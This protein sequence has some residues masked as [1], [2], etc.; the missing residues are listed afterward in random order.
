[1]RCI[2]ICSEN[3]NELKTLFTA[4]RFSFNFLS[5]R[6][7][8]LLKSLHSPIKI[9]IE[10]VNYIHFCIHSQLSLSH[11]HRTPH[12][13]HARRPSICEMAMRAGN[14]FSF[15]TQINFTYPCRSMRVSISANT[16]CMRAHAL[17]CTRTNTLHT[18]RAHL[19]T[20]INQPNC[21]T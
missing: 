5:F 2:H 10:Q 18:H 14:A 8:T 11:T 13:S 16:K 7:R 19:S 12:T 3:A 20:A 21:K 6:V 9:I 17:T 1:M 4:F 15:H